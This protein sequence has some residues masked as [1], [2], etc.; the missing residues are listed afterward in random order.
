MYGV[1]LEPLEEDEFVPESL[2]E[3]GFKADC[4]E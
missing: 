2:A 3:I 1:G 4:D